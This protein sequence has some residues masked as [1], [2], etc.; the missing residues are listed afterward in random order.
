MN[1]TMTKEIIT[2]PEDESDEP[3]KEVVLEDKDDV[4]TEK[5][6]DENDLNER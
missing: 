2:T 3:E 1:E 5:G 6:D 4:N